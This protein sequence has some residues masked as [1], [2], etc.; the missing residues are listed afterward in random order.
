MDIDMSECGGKANSNKRR[1]IRLKVHSV[2][3]EISLGCN[4]GGW[5]WLPLC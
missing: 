3:G 1:K 4:P 2:L 5:F